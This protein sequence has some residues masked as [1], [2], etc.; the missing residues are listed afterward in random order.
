MTSLT[1]KRMGQYQLN[2][3]LGT[4]SLGTVYR[5]EDVNLQRQAAVKV[6]D[7]SLSQEADL[8]QQIM[9]AARLD[10][11]LAHPAIVPLYDFAHEGDQLYVAMGYVDGVSLKAVFDVLLA[12]QK[13][14]ELA[15][16]L[17]LMAQVADT[18]GHAHQEGVWHLNLHPG[19]ILLR[20]SQ[21][22]SR[23]SE[24][25]LRLL[26]TDFGMTAVPRTGLQTAVSDVSLMLPYLSPEQCVGGRV[27]GRSDLYSLGIILYEFITGRPPFTV[28]T[29]EHAINA[30]SIEPHLPLQTYRDDIP[31][32]LERLM[33]ML[34]A[35]KA[36][37]RIQQAEQLADVMRYIANDVL[38]AVGTP[39][40]I[41]LDDYFPEILMMEKT[42][43]ANEQTPVQP[44][45]ID[46]EPQIVAQAVT[47]A[48]NRNGNGHPITAVP[49]GH[50]IPQPGDTL[51]TA[52]ENTTPPPPGSMLLAN[53][54]T[55]ISH[56]TPVSEYL[57][58]AQRGR[59]PRRIHLQKTALTIGRSGTNDVVLEALDVSRQHARLTQLEDGWQIEDLGSSAGTFCNGRRLTP[60]QPMPWQ[61]NDRV[62]I[63]TYFL[64]WQAIDMKDEAEQKTDVH[65]AV[66]PVT[67]L[68]QLPQGGSEAQSTS[69]QFSAALYPATINISP[70]AAAVVQI[71]LF[72]QALEKDEYLLSVLGLP[73]GTADLAETYVSLTPGARVSLPLTFHLPGKGSPQMRTMRAGKFPFQLLLVSQKNEQETAVL[74]GLLIVPPVEALSASIWPS[75]MGNPGRSRVLIR[76]E[77]NT[78]SHY[79][80]VGREEMNRLRFTGQE[81]RIYLQPGEAVSRK[82]QVVYGK[83][84]FFG[85]RFAYPF[86]IEVRTQNGVAKTCS[87]AIRVEPRVPKW[88]FPM[89]QFALVAMLI[90]L[91]VGVIVSVQLQSGAAAKNAGET[92]PVINGVGIND[93]DSDNLS[94]EEE[95]EFG[96]DPLNPDS[97]Y[98][99]LYDGVEL[100]DLNLN[101][102]NIDTDEDGLPDGAEVNIYQSDPT[103]P[104]TDN[105]G[106]TDRQEVERQT[107]PLRP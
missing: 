16:I 74:N 96:T 100:H 63:G 67:E 94:D 25:S 58:V 102:L 78:P 99:G 8:R 52:D 20:Q 60:H 49:T 4:G 5:A 86:E 10:S 43:I 70:D 68:F 88:V 97:D 80:M 104:D 89:V 33:Q 48:E 45:R 64:S 31:P 105:D 47:P 51:P 6:I 46:S 35:K 57:F 21:R 44:H 82:L 91:V 36:T 54:P 26:L 41:H 75:Q 13:R 72:N 18:L 106:V 85:E 9:Q 71:D 90:L 92:A 81:G 95:A 107:D 84:P 56:I 62:Q 19:N 15:E 76:N 23:N 1:N 83:R 22:P 69:G 42:M 50:A 29:I 14:L 66:E 27:N 93:S 30:H 7:I 53:M 32:E 2:M 73:P 79:S 38:A 101:P 3:R 98:D 12:W 17:R 55:E 103:R 40:A 77:G 87:A 34:L 24:S 65:L 37:E 61:D 28:E 59:A 11:K 39:N